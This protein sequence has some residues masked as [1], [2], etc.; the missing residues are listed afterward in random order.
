LRETLV[1]LETANA[2]LVRLN[3]EKNEFMGIAAHDLK[4]PLTTIIMGA[5][6]MTS[7]NLPPRYQSIADSISQAGTRMRDLITNLL[8]ANAIEQGRFLSQLERCELAALTTQTVANNQ[9]AAAR[10]N[11]QLS[12]LLDGA[13]PARA[14]RHAAVQIL[15]NLI[16]NAVKYSPHQTTVQI[17]GFLSGANACIS[18]TDQGPGISEADQRKLFGKFTRLSAKP[19]GGESSSGLGLSIVKKLAEAMN[20]RVYCVSTLGAGATFTVELPVWPEN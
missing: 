12:V 20:G 6:L 17:R 2:E 15:D 16:S 7:A 5:G 1:R 9:P 19:T 14:D 18:V 10:K 3:N 11:I 4:N 13:L 8:D